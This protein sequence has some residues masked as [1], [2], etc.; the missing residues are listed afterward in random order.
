MHSCASVRPRGRLE[1]EEKANMEKEYTDLEI[2]G[3]LVG[4]RIKGTNIRE[5]FEGIANEIL[6]RI[7]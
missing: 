6:K 7:K 1:E 2:N 5:D 4:T 3:N